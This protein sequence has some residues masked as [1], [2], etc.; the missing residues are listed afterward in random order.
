MKASLSPFWFYVPHLH[1][2][3]DE[4]SNKLS[5]LCWNAAR[6]LLQTNGTPDDIELAVALRGVVLCGPVKIDRLAIAKTAQNRVEQDLYRFFFE[7]SYEI[8]AT[9]QRG[10]IASAETPVSPQQ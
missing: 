7:P 4:V 3:S 1:Q 6:T 9:I 10:G 8:P 2:Y 5:D